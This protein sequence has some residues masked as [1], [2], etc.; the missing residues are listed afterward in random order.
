[1]TKQLLKGLR[2]IILCNRLERH[3][4]AFTLSMLKTNAVA[5]RFHSVLDSTL[6]HCILWCA[7]IYLLQ[8]WYCAICTETLANFCTHCTVFCLFLFFNGICFWRVWANHFDPCA[9]NQFNSTRFTLQTTLDCTHILKSWY[10]YISLVIYY[11]H[12][13][14]SPYCVRVFN[15]TLDSK[16]GNI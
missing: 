8:L 3:A 9:R 12:P 2:D 5:W 1:M 7:R 10:Y 6:V 15:K 14:L 4:A 11:T 16:H 13:Q